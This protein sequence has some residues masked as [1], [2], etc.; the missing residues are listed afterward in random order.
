FGSL[1]KPAGQFG[2]WLAPVD[3]GSVQIRKIAIIATATA[4]VCLVLLQLLL[5]RTSVGLHMRAAS[6]DF[7][8]ARM[9]GVRANRVI[10]GAVLISGALAATAAVMLSVEQPQITSTFA[11][12]ETIYVLMG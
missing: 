6:M 10:G 11:L 2:N 1:G 7:R 3:I 9:L 4:V 8:T 12:P 5:T